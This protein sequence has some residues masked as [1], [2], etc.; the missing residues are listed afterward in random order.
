MMLEKNL[1][2]SIQKYKEEAFALNY[3]L[4][5]NPEV[6][7]K[8]YN[9][10]KKIME[11]LNKHQIPTK[12]K[13]LGI[14]TSFFGEVIKKENSNINI[15]ILTEYDAL[16]EV[17][18]ACGHS[19]SAAI[20]VL[21]A[22]ALKDNEKYI[23]ANI[24]IIGTPDEEDIGMKVTMAD[25]GVFDKYDCAIMVH[26]GIKN[27][28]NWKMLAFETY[29][30]EFEGLPSHTAVAPWRGR[31]ALDGLMLSIH[32][33]DLMRKCTKRNTIIEGFIQ[34]GGTATNIIPD[35]AKAKYTFRS[36]SLK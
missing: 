6:S 16:P 5:E 34:E 7:G 12:E 18:H 36:D 11:I 4:V 14:D 3:Y 32:A 26:L 27:I 15:A 17:G 10:C 9:S 1:I 31:S 8:E 29:E 22:L 13:F 21:A 2:S 19:A 23:N 30:I 25:K 35:K 24:D 20:S 28:P 33:F